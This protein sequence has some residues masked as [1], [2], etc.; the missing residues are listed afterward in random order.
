VTLHAGAW[1]LN[2][3][4]H[5]GRIRYISTEGLYIGDRVDGSTWNAKEPRRIDDKDINILLQEHK[6]HQNPTLYQE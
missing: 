4:G 3:H 2:E 6:I 5:I 1:A